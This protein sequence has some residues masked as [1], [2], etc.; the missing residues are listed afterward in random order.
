M[1]GRDHVRLKPR[2]VRLEMNQLPKLEAAIESEAADP[3]MRAFFRFLIATGCRRSEALWIKWE[4]VDL[5][6]RSVTFRETKNTEDRLS[7]CR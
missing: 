5:N 6:Q 3:Y 7:L 2:Q 4:D 1:L